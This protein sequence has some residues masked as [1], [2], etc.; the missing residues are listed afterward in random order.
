M[1]K[2]KK[3]SCVLVSKSPIAFIAFI[4]LL[5]HLAQAQTPAEKQI[6]NSEKIN[7]LLKKIDDLS[8]VTPVYAGCDSLTELYNNLQKH[9][10]KQDSI[11]AT[12]LASSKESKPASSPQTS[13]IKVG[14]GNYIVLG[15]YLN[16]KSA[17]KEQKK[18]N[19]MSYEIVKTRS[20]KLYY[21]VQGIKPNEKMMDVLNKIRKTVEKEAWWVNMTAQ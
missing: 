15:V 4:F 18:H 20:G 7:Q 13:S 6:K 1:K 12:L 14:L 16:E 9:V 3:L 2:L 5:S 19:Y 10:L 17:I 11:I 21:I 8:L